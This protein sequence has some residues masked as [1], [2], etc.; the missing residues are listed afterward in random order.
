[1]RCCASLLTALLCLLLAP[2]TAAQ[3][4]EPL[5]LES[6]PIAGSEQRDGVQIFRGIPYAA[7]P[8]GD[9]RWQ[10]PQPVAPWDEVRDSSRFAASC[11]Q[12]A[13]VGR[14]NI[15]VVPGAPPLSEDCLY[16]NVWTA[17]A[18]ED[19]PRPVMVYFYGGLFTEGAGS[20]PLYD[21]TQLAQ[22]GAV[23][24]TLNYRLGA[25]GFF[26]HPALAE[27]SPQGAAGNY[28]IQDMLAA[29]RWVQANIAVFGGDPDR[30]T[31]FGQSAG[32]MAIASLVASP[33]SE[34]LF[35][36]AI[37]QSGAWM[38]LGMGRMQTLAAVQQRNA[39]A[40]ATLG[41]TTAEDL[42]ALPAEQVAEGLRS[43]GMLVDGWVIPEDPS[44]TFA[45]GRQ[46]PV[47]VLVGSNS[48]EGS[49][50][51]AGPT[52]VQWREQ[53]AARWG[54]AANT[55]LAYYPAG[56]DAE[57]ASSSQRAFSDG[58]SWH[59][60][61][62][63]G[64]QAALGQ[65]AWVYYFTQQPPVDPGV[66]DLGA[67]HSAEIPYVFDNLAQLRLYPDSG[68]PTLAAASADERLLAQRMSAYWVNFARSGDPNGEGLPVWPAYRD[69]ESAV[70]ILDTQ[71][72]PE[73]VVEQVKW[74]QYAALYRQQL[75]SYT[76]LPE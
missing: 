5:Q 50:V 16:L 35:H 71:P 13:G 37:S 54:E 38:G 21:G 46:Q 52:A 29:L 66:T 48:D 51:P 15:A 44:L 24:V 62:Y 19:A 60:R 25:F 69:M 40:A 45:A 59:M 75:R 31:V 1:M 47:D 42:R 10:P 22:Q 30:V 70:M 20:I 12:P 68:S 23:V 64:Y 14:P 72:R 11:I 6:G 36:R 73:P 43:S 67:A 28:G 9:L 76:D 55:M 27:E 65:Q 39:E 57:A 49:F 3:L 58:T 53:V 26:T 2:G 32:A 61:L 63:A 7:P 74:A 56:D 34:G 33:L 8:V 18:A 17:A 41:A 4:P